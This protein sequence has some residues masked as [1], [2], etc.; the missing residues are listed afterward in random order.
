MKALCICLLFLVCTEAAWPQRF[1][2][3]K[4]TPAD[5]AALANALRA[6]AKQVIGVYTDTTHDGYLNNLFRLQM[7]AGDYPGAHTTLEKLRTLNE[8]ANP[9]QS[10]AMLTP[11]ELTVGAK[12]RESTTG[13]SFNDAMSASFREMFGRLD[14]K[15]A[16][17]AVY[18]LWGPVGRFRSNVTAAVTKSN[19][20]GG[21]ELPDALDLIQSYQLYSEYDALIPLTEALIQEDDAKRYVIQRD[22]QIRTGGGATLCTLI[23]RSKHV[24]GQQ[25]TAL[26][27]TIYAGQNEMGK[28]RQAAVHGYV[29]VVA[30]ARGKGCSPDEIRPWEV[31]AQ[32]TYG[33]IDWISKQPWSDGQVGM[34]GGSY[35][36]FAQWSAA[37]HVHPALKTI[38]PW[39]PVHPGLVLPMSNN[40]FQNANYQWAFYVTDNKY[41]DDK[42]NA[43]QER[44]NLLNNRWYQSGKPYRDIDKVDGVPNQVLQRQLLHPA[45]D[46]YWQAMTPYKGDFA[47][48]HIPV[49]QITGYFDPAQISAVHYLTEHYKYDAHAEH[50]LIIGPYDHFGAQAAQKPPFVN[51]YAIDPVAEFNTPEITYEWFDYV[52][53]GGGKP[54]ILRDK[55]NF[56]VMGANLWRGTP[57]L[58]SMSNH[59]LTLY[60]SNVKTGTDYELTTG[61]PIAVGVL[62]QTVDFANRD[63][64]ATNNLY[65]DAVV[66]KELHLKNGFTFISK[67]FSDPTSI[68]GAISGLIRASINKRDMDV[69]LAFYE[70]TPG[71]KYFNLGYYVGRASFSHNMTARHLLRPGAIESI[72][73][74]R[75]PL[76]S[77][78]LETGSR[79]L[80]QL[81]VNKNE[82]DQL[83]YRTGKDV[84]DES[85]ADAKVPLQVRWQ[86][87]SYITVPIWK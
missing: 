45:F 6:L 70:L 85:I 38:V 86:N 10:S 59:T 54:D 47:R 52:M 28:A 8:T 49:L 12:L 15:A 48:I 40:V 18:W 20:G 77:R 39:S 2:F 82:F 16:S 69:T 19:A 74:M 50:Y 27:F 81:T 65:P 3:S 79:L 62:E 26:N 87:D 60:L 44:W 29:G 30:E 37:K 72:P 84:S 31:E 76:V 80:V 34:Y 13:S 11:D 22:V 9:Q 68:A 17:D 41:L 35:E 43:D 42:A 1:E 46:Q 73:I 53:K 71:G 23:V 67:P 78:Q 83:D 63:E 55:I 5:D 24:A 36:G 33:V 66:T 32:D 61:R 56:E 51:G 25:P 64:S 75:T 21:I 14:D 58:R 57:S 7:V 4:V